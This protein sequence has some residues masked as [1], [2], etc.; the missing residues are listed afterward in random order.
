M[1]M[2]KTVLI[3]GALGLVFGGSL[4]YCGR[5]SAPVLPG[6]G[7]RL[8][9]GE[10]AENPDAKAFIKNA[11]LMGYQVGVL[12]GYVVR[13]VPAW[14]NQL[15][16]ARE[17][18]IFLGRMNTPHAITAASLDAFGQGRA[19]ASGMACGDG[20]SSQLS[21]GVMA[22]AAAKT[23]QE[24]RRLAWVPSVILHQGTKT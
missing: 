4:G 23:I 6:D 24:L 22:N 20:D 1:N 14:K 5:D 8:I 19:S 21:A 17:I 2:L 13:C 16:G 12:N 3:G 18:T 11:G 7:L 10:D 9:A 15:A